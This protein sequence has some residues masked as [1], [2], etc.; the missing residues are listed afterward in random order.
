MGPVLLPFFACLWLSI[1]LNAI[2]AFELSILRPQ[3]GSVFVRRGINNAVGQWKL[4]RS[5][6]VSRINR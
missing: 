2:E 5:T 3:Q 1:E 4:E 6:E